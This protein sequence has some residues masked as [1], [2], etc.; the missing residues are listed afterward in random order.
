MNMNDPSSGDQTIVIV[1]GMH[2]SGTS[3]ITR[4]LLALGVDLG[5]R[6]LGSAEDNPRGFW[7]NRAIV[8]LN[9]AILAE[10]GSSWDGL[11]LIDWNRVPEVRK[12]DLC[13]RAC[14][15]VV[16][17][18]G[19]SRTIAFKDPR[20]SRLLPVWQDACSALGLHDRY[21]IVLRNPV[22]VA[23]SL[24]VRNGFSYEKSH[25]LWLLHVVPA[26]LLTHGKPRCIVD[27]DRLIES[28][29]AA[30]LHVSDALGLPSDD[31]AAAALQEFETE[32]VSKDLRHSVYDTG[33]VAS[34]TSAP[35]Y[36]SALYSELKNAASG[37][38]SLDDDGLQL[39]LRRANE[40]L[41]S[42]APLLRLTETLDRR[43]K[44]GSVKISALE[45][46][47]E[48]ILA[49]ND[50]LSAQNRQN[51]ARI[52]SLSAQ[53]RQIMHDTKLTIDQLHAD[54]AALRSSTSWRLTAPM[55]FVVAMMRRLAALLR[56]R[57][58]T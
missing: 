43:N 27:Y 32:F 40:V 55:R 38:T 26:L 58:R 44:H 56:P 51:L 53:N 37:E 50:S 34:E 23:R 10:L 54:I 11:G 21:A 6:M 17:E 39:A 3:T 30:L 47:R 35:L 57:D 49:R 13:R 4:G 15:A 12:Q 36:V 46:E 14:R 8:N 52:D 22:S 29:A 48:Q 7:E 33:A 41:T 5:T 20:T 19:N 1:L 28:P 24:E 25:M 16:Q 2:R 42:F 31:V 18:F 45:R 9:E